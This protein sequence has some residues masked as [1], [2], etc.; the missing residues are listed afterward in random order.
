VESISDK[1][2]NKW[3][4]YVGCRCLWLYY[5]WSKTTLTENVFPPTPALTLN[6]TLT[7]T[8]TLTLKYNNVFEL[9]SF[10]EIVSATYICAVL[11]EILRNV[12]YFKQYM[13]NFCEFYVY[14]IYNMIKYIHQ[15]T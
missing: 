11:P 2:R 15:L 12:V 1:R 4:G 7:L 8:I 13:H 14:K 3:I 6:L 10:F 9:T 5:T